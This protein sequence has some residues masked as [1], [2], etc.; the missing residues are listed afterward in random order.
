MLLKDVDIQKAKKRFL[1]YIKKYPNGK[2]YFQA[3]YF[4]KKLKQK[5]KQIKHKLPSKE[6]LVRV[7]IVKTTKAIFKG[8]LQING[9]IYHKANLTYK[10]GR[11]YFDGKFYNVLKIT[12]QQP[13]FLQNENKKYYG[14]FKITAYKNKLYVVNYVD[15]EKYLYGVVTSESY[16]KWHI[17]ALKAQA[18]ASRSFVYYQMQVRKNWLYDVRDDTFDQ[19]YKGV[20]GITKKSIIATNK[21]KGEVLLFNDQVIL[22]QFTAN[23]GW[24]SSS[25]KEIFN[26]DFEYLYTHKDK[27]SYKMPKGMW[28]KEISIKKLSKNLKKIGLNFGTII[29]IKPYKVV[30]SGRVVKVV[31]N[32]EK[33]KKILKTYTSIRRAA[34]LDD[35]LLK[36]IIKQNNKFIFIGGGYGHGVG[37]SQWGGEAMAKDGYSYKKILSYYYKNIS[38]KKLWQ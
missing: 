31:I 13:I 4:L 24:Y 18:V 16:S 34:K 30:K 3:N 11:I 38:I 26:V 33:G 14:F 19:V 35:I 1:E 32:G 5:K 21:T 20:D 28:Q 22:A 6:P 12:S 37:Y 23:S 2:F 17:E 25:S 15:I 29:D 9:K 10:N 7:L 36:K 27:F 8:I